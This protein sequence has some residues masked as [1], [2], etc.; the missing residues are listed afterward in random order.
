MTK[1]ES[2]TPAAVVTETLY[3]IVGDDLFSQTLRTMIERY[4]QNPTWG[5]FDQDQLLVVADRPESA[6]ILAIARVKW[7]GRIVLMQDL[8]GE[9]DDKVASVAPLMRYL[10]EERRPDDPPVTRVLAYINAGDEAVDQAFYHAGFDARSGG[11]GVL[12]LAL[13]RGTA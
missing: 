5:R 6:N 8:L 2:A 3:P 13:N 1:P 9:T 10:T 7:A 12:H 4:A 11:I